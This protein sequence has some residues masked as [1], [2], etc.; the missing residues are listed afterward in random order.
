MYGSMLGA[1]DICSRFFVSQTL[2]LFGWSSEQNL[3]LRGSLHGAVDE[4]PFGRTKM[5]LGD[6]EMV[7]ASGASFCKGSQSV[8]LFRARELGAS[9]MSPFLDEVTTP[10]W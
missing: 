10:P 4:E 1:A 2:L 8:F 5:K 7:F 9:Q 3:L 6:Q